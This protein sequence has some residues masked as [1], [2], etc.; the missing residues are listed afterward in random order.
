MVENSPPN[1]GDVG[2]IPAQGTKIPHAVGQLNPH[3]TTREA[4]TP[5]QKICMRQGRS[6]VLQL[7]PDTAKTQI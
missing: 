1:A 2:S 4:L 7:R 5:Q 3:T 6:H